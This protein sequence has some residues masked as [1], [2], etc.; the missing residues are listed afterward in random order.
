M[1][2]GS[3]FRSAAILSDSKSKKNFLCVRPEKALV[4]VLLGVLFPT[5][6][7]KVDHLSCETHVASKPR[8]MGSVK[9]HG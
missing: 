2:L 1:Q 6:R 4:E 5:T 3:E 7:L 9:K 8:S